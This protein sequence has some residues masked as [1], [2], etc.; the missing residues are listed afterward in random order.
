MAAFAPAFAIDPEAAPPGR[1]QVTELLVVPV[2]DAVSGIEPPAAVVGD[3]GEIEMLMTGTVTGGLPVAASP[4]P[5]DAKST[6]TI[7]ETREERFSSGF[8]DSIDK[9]KNVVRGD[10]TRSHTSM[11]PHFTVRQYPDRLRYCTNFPNC[12]QV[13]STTWLSF[14]AC[15]NS[16]LDTTS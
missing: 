11:A 10:A 5:H 9:V 16:A 1:S 7:G 3:V 4:P 12:R 6:R 8:T 13:T 14:N 2:T 15:R